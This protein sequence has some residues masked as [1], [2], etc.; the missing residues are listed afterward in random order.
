MTT[1]DRRNGKLLPNPVVPENTVCYTIRIPNAVQ[2]RAA[3]LGQI[4][5]LGEWYTWDHATDGTDCVPCEKAAQIWRNAL[6][7]ATWSDECGGDMSC[8]DVADCIDNNEAVQQALANQI[9]TN[10]IIKQ[11]IFNAGDG[12][13][14]NGEPTLPGIPLSPSQMNE[15]L[16]EIDQC[17]FDPFWAQVE[18]FVDY[19][20]NLG[21][22]ALDQLALYSE[23]IEAGQSAAK[24]PAL[25]GKLKNSTTAGK[26]IEFVQWAANTMKTAYEAS[27]NQANRDAIKCALFCKNRD[28]CLITLQDTWIVLNERLGGIL[29][30]SSI[31]TLEQLADTFTTVVFNPALA[32]DLWMTFIIG[33]AKTA[34]FLGLQGI[35]ETIQL[36]LKIAVNDANNDWEAK[37]EDCP[38]PLCNW[39]SP[40][41]VSFLYGNVLSV[42]DD[43]Y[44]VQAQTDGNGNY[45]V[46]W[47][48]K[49]YADPRSNQI[50]FFSLDYV[51]GE[52][53][54][55]RVYGESTV[56]GSAVINT[57]TDP[58]PL[59]FPYCLSYFQIYSSTVQFVAR[60]GFRT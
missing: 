20:L 38:P 3:F 58:G 19:L 32:L 14:F 40:A 16:N 2:Y 60:I 54:I 13:N 47:P 29:N 52:N 10:E 46:T 34:G 35:D 48:N 22:D 33:S 53:A 45:V 4:N 57:Q 55:N 56:P 1:E 15:R 51:N 30:P 9:S 21:Q 50:Q 11:A 43:V 26:A 36:V 39:P 24:M 25:V 28:A 42:I 37:C 59:N 12:T 8:D 18:Q 31:N 17:A 7:E 5:I 27:D 44:T 6:Y 41:Q 49:P 23:A